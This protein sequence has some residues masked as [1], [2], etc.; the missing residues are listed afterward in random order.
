MSKA[1]KIIEVAFIDHI[2]NEKNM[3][4]I[5]LVEKHCTD[6]QLNR[7]ADEYYTYYSTGLTPI[8][9]P[10]CVCGRHPLSS[11]YL[12]DPFRGPGVAA[13]LASIPRT[14]STLVHQILNQITGQEI[15]KTHRLYADHCPLVRPLSLIFF[16]VRHPYDTIYSYSRYLGEEI[17][18]EKIDN[19]FQD[20]PPLYAHLLAQSDPILSK[21]LPNPPNV[22]SFIRYE[23][24]WNKTEELVNHLYDTIGNHAPHKISALSSDELRQITHDNSPERISIP[25]SA[26]GIPHIGEL[27]GEPGQGHEQL[28]QKI[29]NYIAEK[30]GHF[31]EKLWEYSL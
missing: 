24:F 19:I 13:C 15:K 12:V 6:A 5:H 3:N 16:T 23:D 1:N 18:K 11:A 4:L 10:T 25:D 21:M 2:W 14:G 29:K 22:M 20:V 30:Y 17:T 26:P 27:R 28:P 7:I 31:F 9:T 8:K